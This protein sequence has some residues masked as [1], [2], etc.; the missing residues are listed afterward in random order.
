[1]VAAVLT[2]LRPAA[3]LALAPA[4]ALTLSACGGNDKTAKGFDA[5]SVSGSF[6]QAAKFDCKKQ[7]EPGKAVTKTLIDGSGPALAD[8]DTALVNLTVGDGW[9]Q[10]TPITTY[11]GKYGALTLPIGQT[12]QPQAIGDLFSGYLAKY[13]KAGVKVGTRIAIA[14]GTTQA[15]PDYTTAF[16]SSHIDIGNDDGLV[17]VADVAGT[18]PKSALTEKAPSGTAAKPAGWAPKVVSKSGAPTALGFKGVPKPNGKLRTTTL[19]K[20]DGEP[21]A[22]GSTAVVRYLGQVY[23]AAKPFDE[24]FSKNTVLSALVGTKVQ[25]FQNSDPS[26]GNAVLPVIT[27]WS[28]GLVGVPVGSRVI[29]QIPPKLGYGSKGNPSAKIKGTDTLYFVVDVLAGA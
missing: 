5:V 25:P 7:M 1:M 18:V 21:L 8:G 9:T 2:R 27:G 11:G 19:I 15:F 23:G 20:G 10:E 16:A 22:D 6:G 24:D 28:Q 29:I 14:V 17:I 3:V 13:V 12:G 26:K 4:L